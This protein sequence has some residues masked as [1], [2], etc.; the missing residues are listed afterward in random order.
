MLFR[1]NFVKHSRCV[2]NVCQLHIYKCIALFERFE[3]VD[4]LSSKIREDI[5]PLHHHKELIR[6]KTFG[7]FL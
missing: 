1:K 4:G 5:V 6:N 2:N 3:T 7:V